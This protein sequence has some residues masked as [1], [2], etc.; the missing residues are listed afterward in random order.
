MHILENKAINATLVIK[1][2]NY[3]EKENRKW[4]KIT[5][6]SAKKCLPNL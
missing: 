1:E 5:G 2:S 3:Q 6:K 4:N